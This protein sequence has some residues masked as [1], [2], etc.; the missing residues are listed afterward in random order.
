[1]KWWEAP[2]PVPWHP[3]SQAPGSVSKCWG[4]R[5]IKGSSAC[6][7]TQQEGRVGVGRGHRGRRRRNRTGQAGSLSSAGLTSWILPLHLRAWESPGS[8]A[9]TASG[10]RMRGTGWHR[11]GQTSSHT[12]GWRGLLTLVPGNKPAMWSPGERARAQVAPGPPTRG[13]PG[14]AGVP[15]G[16]QCPGQRL[17]AEAEAH[18]GGAEQGQGRLWT[19]D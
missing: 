13:H 16:G 3:T 1:M 8:K 12:P 7:G 5:C 17:R 14:A 9:G 15:S 18:G 11:V 4:P 6:L 19:C 2:F 10:K